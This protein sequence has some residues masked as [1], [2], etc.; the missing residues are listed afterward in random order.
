MRDQGSSLSRGRYS[1]S[2]NICSN[3]GSHLEH[4]Y[5]GVAQYCI[6][7]LKAPRRVSWT[8]KNQPR[9]CD[10]FQRHDAKM[11]DRAV[12]LINEL[13]SQIHWK[14]SVHAGDYLQ[15]SGSG[16]YDNISSTISGEVEN[17][18]MELREQRIELQM[19]KRREIFLYFAVYFSVLLLVMFYLKMSKQ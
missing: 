3:G 15:N 19:M 8:D 17:L 14:N 10:F 9:G 13:S 7:G 16:R 12:E 1:S 4:D 5:E 18:L 2:P 11:D 6:R